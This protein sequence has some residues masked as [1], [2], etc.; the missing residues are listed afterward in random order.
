LTEGVLQT[1]IGKDMKNA[2][3]QLLIKTRGINQFFLLQGTKLAMWVKEY[4]V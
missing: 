4:K 3:F 1:F 2:L